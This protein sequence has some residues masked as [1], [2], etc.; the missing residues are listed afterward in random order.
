M[1][2]R[3]HFY[4]KKHLTSLGVIS[5]DWVPLLPY[6]DRLCFILDFDSPKEPSGLL[7]LRECF[8]FPFRLFD[9]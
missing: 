1:L 5:C 2:S 6:L 7:M 8:K 9:A 4:S 3:F